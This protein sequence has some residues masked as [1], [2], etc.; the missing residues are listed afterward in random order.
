MQRYATQV[1]QTLESEGKV[2]HKNL[3]SLMEGK[4]LV[5]AKNGLG[6]FYACR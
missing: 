3:D 6:R 1:E 2:S 5:A 4:A